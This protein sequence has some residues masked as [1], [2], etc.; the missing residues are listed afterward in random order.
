MEYGDGMHI[1]SSLR[2]PARLGE[3]CEAAMHARAEEMSIALREEH[4]LGTSSCAK[5]AARA[6]AS[7]GGSVGA[8]AASG[9]GHSVAA[10]AA[11]G[12]CVG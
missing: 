7:R 10:F 8:R 12:G 1:A 5:L 4:V 2:W 11:S 3:S 6:S 9:V